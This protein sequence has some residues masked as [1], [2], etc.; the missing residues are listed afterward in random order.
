MIYFSVISSIEEETPLFQLL[1]K[2][3]KGHGNRSK[4]QQA[5]KIGLPSSVAREG[6]GD[7]VALGYNL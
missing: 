3:N 6:A 4:I 2:K 1:L 7:A 5:I